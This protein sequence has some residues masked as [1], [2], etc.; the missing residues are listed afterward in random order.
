M[1]LNIV[2]LYNHSSR[3]G[4]DNVQIKD[5]KFRDIDKHYFFVE[6]LKHVKKIYKKLHIK[7]EL[8][9]I[10]VYGYID[11]EKGIQFRILGN[12]IIENGTT[13]IENDFINDN[14]LIPYDFFEDIEIKKVPFD[15]SS[16]IIGT[17]LIEEQISK[18][19]SDASLLKNR[20]DTRIDPYRDLRL[21]D[22]V[23]FLLLNREEQQENVWGR[24]EAVEDNGLLRCTLL[25]KTKK[26]FK[27][28]QND[29]IY[30]KYVEHPKYKGLM[31]VKKV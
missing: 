3:Y 14:Y 7:D 19:Y 28:K 5:L 18:F 4:C 2:L 15:T 21:I 9:S 13:K 31:F 24:I 8:N 10:L 17:S 26:S 1:I 22:D 30:I 23:Q 11:H 12:V 27:L 29:K 16:K 20:E 25:D 6:N